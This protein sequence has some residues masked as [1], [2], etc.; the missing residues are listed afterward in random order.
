MISYLK[1][2]KHLIAN[3][4]EIENFVDRVVLRYGSIKSRF[5]NG[6]QGLKF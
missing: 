2:N 3:V 1:D 5:V 6:Q 4:D